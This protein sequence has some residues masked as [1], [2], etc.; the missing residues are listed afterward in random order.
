MTSEGWVR[1]NGLEIGSAL[2]D[3]RDNITANFLVFTSENALGAQAVLRSI[4]FL[5]T[6]DQMSCQLRMYYYFA[7]VSSVLMVGL[8]MQTQDQVND[9]WKQDSSHKNEWRRGVITI[10]S[11]EPFQDP[12][13]STAI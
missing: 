6:D 1:T 13:G 12:A 5:P 4:N 9:I 11:S 8:Q 7:D 10:S 2:L 3:Q